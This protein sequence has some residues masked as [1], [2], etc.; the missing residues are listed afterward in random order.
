[1][2][3]TYR[4]YDNYEQYIKHQSQKLDKGIK[5]S[6]TRF[7]TESF[8]HNV[9]SYMYRFEK[10]IKFIKGNKILCLGAR[11]GEEVVAFRRMGFIDTIGVD[12]NP[13]INNKYVIKGDF[14]NLEF[15]SA[16]FDTLYTNCLDHAWGLKEL[17]FEMARVLKSG[18]RFVTEIGHSFYKKNQNK[19]YR[20]SLV[21]KKNKF[22]S[23]IWKTTGDIRKEL[24]EFDLV[25][26]F[27]G[28]SNWV[29]AIYDKSLF[30]N[31]T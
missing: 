21:S 29:I 9:E 5:S 19:K 4:S 8:E 13:G 11:L 18:G 2:A 7:S 14:H 23:I 24:K 3:L 26:E 28:K 10:L 15:R 1:M 16:T 25:K 22:E 31:G 30:E 12:I 27:N 6:R 17:S 20:K